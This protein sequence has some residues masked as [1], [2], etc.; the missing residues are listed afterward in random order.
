MAFN[1]GVIYDVAN[2][3][4]RKEKEGNTF[5]PEQFNRILLTCSWEKANE[6]YKKFEESHIIT[7]CLRPLEKSKINTASGPPGSVASSTVVLTDYW[8]FVSAK[9]SGV[10]ADVLTTNQL[11]E[12]LN[13]PMLFPESWCP[14]CHYSSSGPFMYFSFFPSGGISYEVI[15]LNPPNE[16]YFDYYIN[17][18]DKIVYLD[19]GE[20]YT[21][22]SGEE[23]R[24]GTTSGTINSI[25]VELSYP[26]QDRIDVMYKVLQK[27]GVAL[28]DEL[29]AQYSLSREVKEETL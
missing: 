25:S 4:I 17:V 16:P 20:S 10:G 7:D 29:A 9:A 2:D 6:E 27:M 23:Y 19:V 21:L 12:Q 28:T 13:N 1:N 5:T 26:E 14:V 3:L 18:N 15:Y 24:D 22:Q 11:S 8:H